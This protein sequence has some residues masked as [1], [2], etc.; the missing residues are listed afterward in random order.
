MNT[1]SRGAVIAMA[2]LAGT[3]GLGSIIAV[4]SSAVPAKRHHV[5][6]VATTQTL[7]SSGQRAAQM[8]P[9]L[10]PARPKT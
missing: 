9:G 3:L 2:M 4:S 6:P 7:G 8:R 1:T 10:I 5:A